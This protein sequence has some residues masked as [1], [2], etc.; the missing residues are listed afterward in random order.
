[1]LTLSLSDVD[2]FDT[3][4]QG[5]VVG[6]YFTTRTRGR[7]LSPVHEDR[8]V[9]LQ[10]AANSDLY[11]KI[12]GDDD[13]VY[14]FE[15]DSTALASHSPVFYNM[16]YET[17]TRGN[18]ESWI[19]ELKGDSVL[20][21]TVM[22]SLLHLELTG[23][24][25]NQEPKPEDVYHVL[26][27]FNKYQI[28]Q[29][30]Y[31]PWVKS[32]TAGFRQGLETTK[33]SMVECLYVAHQ[34]GD[35]KSLKA[36]I[37]H[38]AHEVEID[39]DG[40]ARLASGHLIREVAAI[41]ND[42]VAAVLDIRTA[43]LHSLLDPFMEAH[44]ILMGGTRTEDPKFC[45]SVDHH[46]ECNQAMLG[47]LIGS[48]VQQKLYPVPT[49]GSYN[50][51]VGSLANKISVMEIRGL[52]LP[53]LEPHKQRHSLCRLGQDYL[54]RKLLNNEMY[55]PLPEQLVEHFFGV[56]KRL[57]VYECEKSE[58]RAYEDH[59]KKLKDD[60]DSRLSDKDSGVFDDGG[61]AGVSPRCSL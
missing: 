54:A 37:R 47:S 20:G 6:N 52:F 29:V 55:L 38:V 30:A 35:F 22:L 23:T 41:T 18:Q 1:M 27:V 8:C 48:L 21:L 5:D 56:A 57:G 59:V 51:Q 46:V 24:M 9:N 16:A 17:H 49:V 40:S 53:G 4:N 26:C 39:V 36:C 10:V 33:L 61:A 44:E 3:E 32:W 25:F 43:D 50:G 13:R 15:V 42:L 7:A 45:K 14:I 31:H 28:P 58:F 34:L 11:L 12:K 2:Q 60:D 19:W